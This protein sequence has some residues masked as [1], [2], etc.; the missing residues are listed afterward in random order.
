MSHA[1]FQ[2]KLSEWFGLV[3]EVCSLLTILTAEIELQV[4]K[5]F[6]LVT[7]L[8]EENKAS[9]ELDPSA[10]DSEKQLTMHSLLQQ[11]PKTLLDVILCIFSFSSLVVFCTSLSHF[12][13]AL[14]ANSISVSFC[15][16][17]RGYCNCIN[18][19][20]HWLHFCNNVFLFVFWLGFSC[21]WVFSKQVTLAFTS[22]AA[23]LQAPPTDP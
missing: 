7:C 4:W 9:A 6:N 1:W 18:Q 14:C 17:L 23:V 16:Q 13:C 3:Y 19:L 11:H 8:L 22:L 10:K 5:S 21:S 12:T 2:F 15:I 20:Q